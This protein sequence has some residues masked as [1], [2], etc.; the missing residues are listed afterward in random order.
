MCQ[1]TNSNPERLSRK[2]ARNSSKELFYWVFPILID[3]LEILI[4][5]AKRFAIE[6][7][8]SME[9]LR[10][11]LAGS[12]LLSVADT[13]LHTELERESDRKI[14]DLLSFAGFSEARCRE[15]LLDLKGGGTATLRYKSGKIR[16]F[17]YE[18]L[19][20]EIDGESGRS[21]AHTRERMSRLQELVGRIG[22]EGE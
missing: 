14:V 3:N 9:D 13:A 15:A 2:K 7:G 18:M 16:Q 17:T 8:F 5:N 1:A 22:T 4:E 20:E 21:A 11:R 6:H 10:E 19:L 12:G